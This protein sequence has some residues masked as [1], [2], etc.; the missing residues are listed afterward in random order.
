MKGTRKTLNWQAAD[1]P[2][3]VYHDIFAIHK[4]FYV[5]ESKRVDLP[6]W[7][8]THLPSGLRVGNYYKRKADTAALLESIIE[9]TGMDPWATNLQQPKAV[10]VAR[11]QIILHQKNEVFF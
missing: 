7:K 6:V 2:A 8:I 11:Q 5:S 10:D 4:H 3:T 1:V 9:R